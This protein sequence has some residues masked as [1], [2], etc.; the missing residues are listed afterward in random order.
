[1]RFFQK[2]KINRLQKKIKKL[3]FAR[4]EEGKGDKK[5]E[6][7]T[8]FQLAKLYKSKK[9]DPHGIYELECYRAAA[10]L[11]DPN[12]Q[13]L[14]GKRL[15]DKGR[16]WHD[17]TQGIF[18]SKIHRKYATDFFDEGLRYINEAEMHGHPLAKRL[19]G[20]AYI[21]GWGIQQNNDE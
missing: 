19:H 21:R 16:F 10:H 14:C 7:A 12:A 8:Y 15:M 3:Q 13:Y 20:L 2:F 17:W 9:Y 11:D 4:T 1:M 5:E 18:G 6:I